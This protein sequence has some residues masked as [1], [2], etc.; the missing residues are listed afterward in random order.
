LMPVDQ[1][2]TVVY[3]NFARDEDNKTRWVDL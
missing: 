3:A 2:N 1:P